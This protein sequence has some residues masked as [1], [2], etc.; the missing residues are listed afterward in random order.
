MHKADQSKFKDKRRRKKQLNS[1]LV[2]SL[3]TFTLE[4]IIRYFNV[5]IDQIVSLATGI[6]MPPQMPGSSFL[7]IEAYSRSWNLKIW[8]KKKLRYDRQNHII[9]AQKDKKIKTYDLTNFIVRKQTI[10]DYICLVL[11][12]INENPYEK[13]R[14]V[15]LGF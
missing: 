5:M 13:Q 12:A 1:Q 8:K 9:Y 4:E 11:E 2:K 15:H 6:F 14:T 10:S 3:E 7:I